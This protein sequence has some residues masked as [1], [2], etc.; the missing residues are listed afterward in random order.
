MEQFIHPHE[1]ITQKSL[2]SLSSLASI[3][4]YGY[5]YT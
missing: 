5:I 3:K 2:T 1:N 4:N